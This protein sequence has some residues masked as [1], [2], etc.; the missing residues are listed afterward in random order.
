MIEITQSTEFEI[1]IGIEVH[2]QL[3]TKP[4]DFQQKPRLMYH[5]LNSDQSFF[6]NYSLSNL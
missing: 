1:V 4:K 5:L 6:Y 3:K 2:A